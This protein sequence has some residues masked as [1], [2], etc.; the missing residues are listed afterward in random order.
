MA[1]GIPTILTNAHGHAGFA[2]LAMGL[3]WEW[4]E[5]AYF[6]HG[7]AHNWWKPDFEQLCEALWAVYH[8][9]ATA[10]SRAKDS[11]EIVA[12][13]WTWDNTAAVLH[14]ELYDL[15]EQPLFDSLEW[16]PMERLLYRTRTKVDYTCDIAGGQLIFKKD[17]DYWETADVKRILFEANVLDPECAAE[18]DGGLVPEQILALN[19][20]SARYE[21]CPTCRQKLGSGVKRD[22]LILAEMEA[23]YGPLKTVN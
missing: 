18:N 16:N 6:I 5:A 20:P 8:D 21:F 23:E 11:A 12:Q 7:D 15:I 17:S 14:E 22:D 10:L 2:P 19:K 4:E 1:Q 9:Y 13:H 3:D